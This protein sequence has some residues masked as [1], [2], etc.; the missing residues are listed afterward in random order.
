MQ[1]SNRE[2]L[3]WKIPQ[4]LLDLDGSLSPRWPISKRAR[5]CN[6]SLSCD[7]VWQLSRFALDIAPAINC[8]ELRCGKMTASWVST[9]R[10]AVHWLRRSSWWTPEVIGF[11]PQCY[12]E[13]QRLKR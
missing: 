8:L 13:C 2:S 5:A 11:G 9:V 3:P 6:C 12:L 7:S 10:E 4:I 1:T